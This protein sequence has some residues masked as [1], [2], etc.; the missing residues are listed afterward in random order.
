MGVRSLFGIA[1]WWGGA[2]AFVLEVRS[3]LQEY[4]LF[5]GAIAFLQESDLFTGSDRFLV[6]LFCGEMCD[7]FCVGSAIAVRKD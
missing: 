1:F 7:R 5:T 2:I 4:D 3:P 6:L